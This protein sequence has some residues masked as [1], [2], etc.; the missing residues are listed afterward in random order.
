MTT[1]QSKAAPQPN[2]ATTPGERVLRRRS[3]ERVIG[4]VASGIGDFL[5]VDPLLIRIGFAG[6]MVFGGLGLLLYVGA[7]LLLPDEATDTSIAE[8]VVARA[9]LTPSRLGSLLLILI[10]GVLFFG[11]IAA[12]ADLPSYA[13]TVAAALVVIVVGI[14]LLRQGDAV[15]AALRPPVARTATAAPA[16][17]EP[18]STPIARPVVRRRRR[19]ASPLG[20]YVIGAMLAAVGLLALAANVTVARVDPGQF[21]GLALAVLGVGLVV[22]TWWGRARAL[23]LLGLLLVPI[24]VA[25]SFITTPI[26]GGFGY[27]R[28]QPLSTAELRGEY[29]LVGGSLVLDLTDIEDGDE[30]ITITASVAVGDLFVALP[31][32]AA[33]EL[34]AAVGAGTMHLLGDW[35]EGTGVEDR[36]VREGTGREF[37]LDLETGIGSVYVENCCNAVNR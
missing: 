15:P 30:P 1:Q 27:H 36:Y 32:D 35:K 2:G 24:A 14:V 28:F 3:E 22:G 31:P 7:W 4:G 8:Q 20:W 13:P 21:F 6:L 11:A 34:D 10:G 26:E 29:R 12:G 17:A 23:I 33:V 9:G 37:I 16:D 19:P 25:A 18:L 5:N